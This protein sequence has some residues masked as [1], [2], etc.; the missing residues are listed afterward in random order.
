MVDFLIIYADSQTVPM[1]TFTA[2]EQSA[3]DLSIVLSVERG[4]CVLGESGKAATLHYL[5]RA[6]MR[7]DDIPHNVES[8]ERFL[9]RLFG[10]GA[11]IVEDEIETSL[12]R[13]ENLSPTNTSLSAA[14]TELRRRGPCL[15]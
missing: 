10:R 13:L 5:E 7:I 1:Q 3:A 15:E 4:L 6:G 9:R 2:E 14:V 12:R 8:F 11:I